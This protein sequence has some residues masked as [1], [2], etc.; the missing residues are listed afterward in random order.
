M[1]SAEALSLLHAC[2]CGDEVSVAVL[3]AD[4]VNP[5]IQDEVL[6]G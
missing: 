6:K 1:S 5:N 3:L 2:A 4:G